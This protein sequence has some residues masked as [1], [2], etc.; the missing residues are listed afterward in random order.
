[1]LCVVVVL[2]TMHYSAYTMKAAWQRWMPPKSWPKKW[3]F[4]WE[5]WRDTWKLTY[6]WMNIPGG[7]LEGSTAHSYCNRCSP[8][9]RPLGKRNKTM[10]YARAA[11]SL[12]LS[13]TWV[14]MSPPLSL[15]ASRPPGK[16]SEVC[17]T[18]YTNWKEHLEWNHVMWRWCRKSARK[19]LTPLRSTSITGGLHPGRGGRKVKIYLGLQARPLFQ[20]P[21]RGSCCLWPF[22][23]PEGGVLWAGPHSGPR[24]LHGS[25]GSTPRQNQVIKPLPQLKPLAV[26]KSQVA[27]QSL[28]RK[29]K[30]GCMTQWRVISIITPHK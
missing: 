5:R 8:M 21:A 18:R 2:V 4:Q 16:K 27:M 6:S 20:I 25:H 14:Q 15:W 28:K 26:R 1:M 11:D 12:H 23:E 22:Q 3:A 29:V 7:S 9:Q 10:L 19:S 30:D 13:E 24:C 17:A